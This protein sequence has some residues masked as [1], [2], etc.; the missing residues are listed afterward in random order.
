MHSEG[1]EATVPQRSRVELHPQL[2]SKQIIG[3]NFSSQ[4]R[5]VCLRFTFTARKPKPFNE[6]LP[7]D[8][9]SA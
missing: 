1:C 3:Q 6:V 7:A 5:R 2:G 8:S 4:V 9:A